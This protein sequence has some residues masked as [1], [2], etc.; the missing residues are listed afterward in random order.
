MSE[1]AGRIT[2][3]LEEAWG[4]RAAHDLLKKMGA[5]RIFHGPGE[6]DRGSIESS[7]SIDQFGDHYWVTEWEGAEARAAV[8]DF[9]K[10]RG[11]VSAVVLARP[12]R[13]VPATAVPILG[14]PPEEFQTREL[15]SPAGNGCFLIR[16]LNQRHPGL[17]LDHAPLRGWLYQNA[18][19]WKVLN[20]FAY[21][22]SLS[23]AAARGGA[24]HVTTLDLSKTT[25]AWAQRNWELNQLP[26]DGARWIAGDYFEWLPRLKREGALFDCV[27]LDPPSFSHGKKGVFSTAKDLVKLHALSLEVLAPGGHLVT[28]INSAHVTTRK[29]EGE[30]TQACREQGRKFSIVRTLKLPETFPV[31]ESYLKGWIL[32]EG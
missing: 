17:F 24:A 3:A 13:G 5:L 26:A 6:G 30:V 9:L 20:T 19:R 14:D 29:F 25:L 11:A 15:W 2:Q 8:C 10:K 27:I 22:G 18:R 7:F 28:S 23:V 32:R 12:V 21:T 16:F 4:R 1:R 31:A